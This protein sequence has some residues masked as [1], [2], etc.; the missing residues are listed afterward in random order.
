MGKEHTP[1]ID[2]SD[3]INA[4]LDEH[5]LIKNQFVDIE[6]LEKNKALANHIRQAS[7]QENGKA[8][9][10]NGLAL[11]GYKAK[12]PEWSI[13]AV[14]IERKRK[15][16]I[17]ALTPF[18]IDSTYVDKAALKE[19]TSLVDK[20]RNFNKVHGEQAA[21]ELG[22]QRLGFSFQE[23]DPTIREEKLKKKKTA[24][25]KQ[26]NEYINTYGLIDDIYVDVSHLRTVNE[27][28]IGKLK[29]L[30]SQHGKGESAHQG[31]RIL[32]YSSKP[33][34][35]IAKEDI[36]A[37]TKTLFT[38]EVAKAIYEQEGTTY[39]VESL[40][41][42]A[43]A[44]ARKTWEASARKNVSKKEQ[45]AQEQKI[46]KLE[47][48]AREVWA[49][50]KNKNGY[51]K[52]EWTRFVNK[53]H[54]EL[55]AYYGMTLSDAI[56]G[57]ET[58]TDD[59]IS[60]KLY[61]WLI[62]G[63]S[64]TYS[65][66]RLIGP[67]GAR[68]ANALEKKGLYGQEATLGLLPIKAKFRKKN[69]SN[70][71]KFIPEETSEEDKPYDTITTDEF[72][73]MLEII[74]RYD[75]KLEYVTDLTD[76]FKEEKNL[77]SAEA[78]EFK[79][80]FKHGIGP[81]QN[82]HEAVTYTNSEGNKTAKA[83]LRVQTSSLETLVKIISPEQDDEFKTSI[84]E[85]IK[86][87]QEATSWYDGQMID[88]KIV[89]ANAHQDLVNKEKKRLKKQ[90]VH[91]LSG[92]QIR[93]IYQQSLELLHR[94]EPD[95][96]TIAA[97]RPDHIDKVVSYLQ[98][99]IPYIRRRDI[100]ATGTG[101]VK[102]VSYIAEEQV[103]FVFNA[104]MM[105]PSAD[106]PFVKQFVSEQIK[107]VHGTEK[108]SEGKT[109][110]R[111]ANGDE[112][113]DFIVETVTGKHYLIEVKNTDHLSNNIIREQVNKYMNI[114]HLASGEQ[115]E[116]KLIVFNA[117]PMRL[118]KN[119]WQYEDIGFTVWNGKELSASFNAA[120]DAAAEKWPTIYTDTAMPRPGSLEEQK[121]GLKE[122]QWFIRNKSNMLYRSGQGFNRHYLLEFYRTLNK[123]IEQGTRREKRRPFIQTMPTEIIRPF[124]DW[125]HLY[126]NNDLSE[127]AVK[128]ALFLDL[129][130]AGHTRSGKPT[131]IN[132]L[133]YHNGNEMVV[134]QL[135]ARTPMEERHINERFIELAEGKNYLVDFSGT[136]FDQPFLKER[137]ITWGMPYPDLEHVDLRKYFNLLLKQE[138][139][140]FPHAKLQ[141]FEKVFLNVYRDHDIDGRSIPQKI[142][143]L[144]FKGASKGAEHAIDHS[145]IDMVTMPIMWDY[146]DQKQLL[147]KH[148]YYQQGTLEFSQNI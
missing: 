40:F 123:T 122:D 84:K 1:R 129:E 105:H 42:S 106:I 54:P 17:K 142:Y 128:N 82:Y 126:P 140:N 27:S 64:L 29:L 5:P 78:K 99:H 46:H 11:Y 104:A 143:N 38:Q 131:F 94:E 88:Q 79:N 41:L 59:V 81:T 24:L 60:R 66:L 76:V 85:L 100:Q 95:F 113:T 89:I 121:Q 62:S 138:S 23:P 45:R 6:A 63:E 13:P 37:I 53:L 43:G 120:V 111:S 97:T 33:Q 130:T 61:E 102:T 93:R 133:A 148:Q 80:L 28:L 30:S 68:V 92:E 57:K 101:P 18:I 3:A 15:E 32:G 109:K 124:S 12:E 39:N 69:S 56:K 65:G 90:G 132:G 114:T 117:K 135:I 119:K 147:P 52:S 50:I 145:G 141:T 70:L 55:T 116:K 83:D 107:K 91:L 26:V 98:Q 77:G 14:K 103:R 49:R 96:F 67:E 34:G 144:L 51:N 8:S 31:L 75:K 19:H 71:A 72:R 118:E 10:Y 115:I 136:W 44:A 25:T 73:F 87:E 2:L 86:R 125:Q 48:Q 4:F 47:H 139:L 127:L 7:K 134:H 36:E 9:L 74:K 58:L 21:L 110:L 16:I 35:V 137:F 22:L 20:I 108:G 112:E 146:L